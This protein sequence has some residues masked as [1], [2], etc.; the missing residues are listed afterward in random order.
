LKP[1]LLLFLSSFF[2]QILNLSAQNTFSDSLNEV[3]KTSLADTHRVHVLNDY[4]WELIETKP[5]KAQQSLEE[6]IKLAQ[7]LQFTKGEATAWNELGVLEEARGNLEIAINHYKK[8]LV[9]RLALKDN[10]GVAA[11]YNNLGNA[12]EGMGDYNLAFQNHIAN[13][14]TVEQMR[15]T[16]RIA[17]AHYNIGLVQQEMGD[18]QEASISLNEFR[19]F[20]EEKGDKE[21]MGQAYSQLGHIRFELEDFN[22]AKSWYEKALNIKENTNAPSE[23]AAALTD[24]GNVLDELGQTQPA[25]AAYLKAWEIRKGIN[26]QDGIAYIFNNLGGAHKHLKQYEQAIIYLK[27]AMILHKASGN[28]SGLMEVYNT[29]GDVFFGQG[30]IEDALKYTNLYYELAKKMDD[31][32]F[33]QKAYKDFSKLYE[34]KGDYKL[35]LEYRVKYD[36]LRYKRLNESSSKDYARREAHFSDRRKKID[37]ERQKTQL[38]LQDAELEKSKQRQLASIAGAIALALLALLLYNRNRLRAKANIALAAKNLTIEKERQR[39]DELLKNI[40]PAATAE[41]LKANNKVK[42]ER[43]ESVSVLFTDFKSFTSIAET[44]PPEQLVEELDE[45]FRLFDNIIEQFGL[46]KIKTIGDAYM[47][48]GGL[49][50]RNKTHA[51]DAVAAGLEMQRQLTAYMDEKRKT[52]KIV[53]EMRVG[54]HTGTVVAG[55]VGLKKFA[56]DIWG[57]TVNTAARMES[58]SEIG[59]VNISETTYALVKD[60]YKC[61]FRGKVAAKNKGE[62]SM[63]FVECK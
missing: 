14:N 36:E 63:F 37:N 40:L 11:L 6:A 33:I 23:H 27:Q 49:P 31:G 57:D 28:K 15:D 44:M 61:T 43:Y 5:E 34:Q 47:C 9:F 50:T 26:D 45:C 56:Y 12:Y 24:L 54:I 38:A 35:A 10:K 4:A 58:S 55:I 48:V 17:R 51:A 19:F 41:E 8:A 30:K 25:I 22:G 62:I 16:Q 7:S 59:K 20:V 2:L 42:P 52:G 21:G 32:K 29:L 46:E 18:Y 3:L 39:A 13:L 53:F 60:K 1:F